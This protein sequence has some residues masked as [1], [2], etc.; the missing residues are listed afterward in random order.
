MDTKYRHRINSQPFSASSLSNP[1]FFDPLDS[2]FGHTN[3]IQ[4]QITRIFHQLSL[5]NPNKGI[6]KLARRNLSLRTET[7]LTLIK[8]FAEFAFKCARGFTV[9]FIITQVSKKYFHLLMQKQDTLRE[10][11]KEKLASK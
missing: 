9:N 7:Q 11:R 5:G 1:S 4:S 6:G 8:V 2:M 3:R 10:L